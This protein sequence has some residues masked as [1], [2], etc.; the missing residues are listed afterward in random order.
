MKLFSEK[1]FIKIKRLVDNDVN[2]ISFTDGENY[3]KVLK[4]MYMNT[5][6]DSLLYGFVIVFS[7]FSI[8]FFLF[9]DQESIFMILAMISALFAIVALFFALSN[10]YLIRK[11][12]ENKQELNKITE[13]LETHVE[14]LKNKV[15]LKLNEK[16]CENISD[17]VFTH[18]TLKLNIP[19]DMAKRIK[20]S[21]YKN[22]IRFVFRDKYH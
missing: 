17:I 20:E 7:I 14:S 9:K 2:Q 6:L 10:D 11:Y 16:E 12:K 5:F 22:L 13:I 19:E 15:Y 18:L 8:F 21:V 4:N 3:I 1:T